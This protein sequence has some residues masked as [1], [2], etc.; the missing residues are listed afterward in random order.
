MTD[1][2]E[3]KI[4]RNV[5]WLGSACP[6]GRVVAAASV[7]NVPSLSW[8]S[9]FTGLIWGRENGERNPKTGR[10]VAFPERYG[11]FADPTIEAL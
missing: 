1:I 5:V 11:L 4:T 10:G 6:V 2:T 3:S 9:F 8:V 7:V